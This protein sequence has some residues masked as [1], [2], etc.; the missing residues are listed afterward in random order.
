VSER[1]VPAFGRAG[2][3]ALYDPVVAVTMREGT[4]R[5]AAVARLTEGLGSGSLVLDVG[6]G[7]GSSTGLIAAAT[8]GRVI[9]IDGDGEILERARRKVPAPDVTW[10]HARADE[11]PVDSGTADAAHISLVLHHL[12]RRGKAGALAELRRVLVPGGR[13]VVADFGRP[14]GLTRIG[15]AGIR[16]LDGFETTAEHARGEIPGLIRAAGFAEVEVFDRLDTVWGR[17]ELIAASA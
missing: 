14:A 4:W 1:Y 11:L 10:A 17:L 3:T 7:T 5:P 12:T 15:F 6:A 13:L 16:V 9:G 8:G 2:L